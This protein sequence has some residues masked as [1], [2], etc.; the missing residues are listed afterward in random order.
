MREL[1]RPTSLRCTRAGCEREPF[2]QLEHDD[3]VIADARDLADHA[4]A[5]DDFV[6]LAELL[7]HALVF[8][9]LP[10]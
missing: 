10:H 8:F 2:L 6:T 5:G 4:A 3:A 1:F 9:L 7:E